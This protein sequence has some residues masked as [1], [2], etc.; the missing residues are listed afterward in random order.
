MDSKVYKYM[1]WPEIEAVVYGEEATPR[2]LMAPRI[3]ADG[4]LVQGFFPNADSVEVLVDK[5]TYKMEQQDEAG[6]FA[7]ML[8]MRKVPSYQYRITK[9]KEVCT[10]NDPYAFPVQITEDEEKSLEKKVQDLTDKFI[11][12]IDAIT[13]KKD[14]EIM[15]I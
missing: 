1:D 4:V 13:S 10:V 9:G 7:A 5:K 11:K 8:P 3:T 2:D 15:S 14:Q 6:Y 12:Q